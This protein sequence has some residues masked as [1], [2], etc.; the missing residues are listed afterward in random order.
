M[1]LSNQATFQESVVRHLFL[2]DNKAVTSVVIKK[3][4]HLHLQSPTHDNRDQLNPTSG[5]ARSSWEKVPVTRS[6][7]KSCVKIMGAHP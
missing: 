4:L 3:H 5:H 6:T 2:C 7:E 1:K